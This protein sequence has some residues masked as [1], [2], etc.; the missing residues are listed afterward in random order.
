MKV[1]RVGSSLTSPS[2]DARHDGHGQQGRRGG[3]PLHLG[4]LDPARAAEAQDRRDGGEAER[5][6][7]REQRDAR[8]RRRRPCRTPVPAEAGRSRRGRRTASSRTRA[9]PAVARVPAIARTT[10]ARHRRL[11]GRPSGKSSRRS[12]SAPKTD[13]PVAAGTGARPTR[14][15]RPRR[16]RPRTAQAARKA[17]RAAGS[18]PMTAT[19]GAHRVPRT[20]PGDRHPRDERGRRQRRPRPRSPGPS[21]AG[22]G[23]S[24]AARGRPRRRPRRAR[25]RSMPRGGATARGDHPTPGQATGSVLARAAGR[26]RRRLSAPAAGS[27]SRRGRAAARSAGRAPPRPPRRRAPPRA[28]SPTPPARAAPARAARRPA[29]RSSPPVRFAATTV[30]GRQPVGADRAPGHAQPDAVAAGVGEG[31]LDAER[32]GVD[33]PDRVEPQPPGG[34]R[35]HPRAAAGVEERRAGGAAR[36]VGEQRQARARG[37]VL[38]G[39]EGHAGVDHDVHQRRPGG[40]PG[41][42]HQQA[43]GDLDR[44]V[45]GA[46]A[47]RA[48]AS[49]WGR[50]STRA[51]MPGAAEQGPEAVRVGRPPRRPRSRAAPRPSGRDP[52]AAPGAERRARL[53][54]APARRPRPGRSRPGAPG[55]ARGQRKA[56]LSRSK[57]PSSSR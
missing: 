2:T 3:E 28:G 31:R 45:E 5:G 27:S 1:T 13:D 56:C 54:D 55:A 25:R 38:A 16:R 30:G 23:R 36:D 12:A 44:A 43:A 7:Q 46:P 40:R 4:P 20:A 17:R 8:Q 10:A 19:I 9:A 26:A 35:Q 11:I 53:G 50:A 51:A 18:R 42:P 41:R 33:R 21:P 29:A 22:P 49:S 39:A 52:L 6:D 48:S 34:D 15:P 47:R 57:N 37:G 32:V 24:R 14:R